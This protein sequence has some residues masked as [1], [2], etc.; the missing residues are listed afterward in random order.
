[1]IVAEKLPPEKLARY[2]EIARE[3]PP[4]VRWWL[5]DLLGHIAALENEL[6]RRPRGEA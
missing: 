4:E 1:M 5:L 6:A 2:A 3:V